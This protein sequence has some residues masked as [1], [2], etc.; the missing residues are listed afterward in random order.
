MDDKKLHSVTIAER[1]SVCITGVKEVENATPEK[2]SLL[3]VSGARLTVLGGNLKIN[4]FSADSGV[5]SANGKIDGVK[6]AGEK[7]SLLKR[8]IK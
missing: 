3:L 5:C 1:K 7:I 8:L 2:L 6:Y 4:A